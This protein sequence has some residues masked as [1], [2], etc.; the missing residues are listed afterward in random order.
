[1]KKRIHKC[2][3]CNKIATWSYMPST[4]RRRNFCDDHVPRGCSCNV[5]NIEE[6]SDSIPNGNVMWWS[7]NDDL[8]IDGSLVKNND[9]FFYEELD[10]DGKRSPCCEYD[11]CPEGIEMITKKYF[12]RKDDLIKCLIKAT[13]P[14]FFDMYFATKIKK[15]DEQIDYNQVMQDFCSI[16]HTILKKTNLPQILKFERRLKYFAREY[17][18][19]KYDYELEN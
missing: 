9:S 3:C 7:K 14:K 17:K 18:F 11:Y 5:Y 16:L 13:N 12:I 1:M 10:E 4:S 2:S 19:Y 6:F 15:L 8:N